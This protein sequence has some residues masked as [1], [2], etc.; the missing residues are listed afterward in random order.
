MLPLPRF[1]VPLEDHEE[2]A[3][4]YQRRG[5]AWGL[6]AVAAGALLAA[7]LY[8]PKRGGG[9]VRLVRVS[10]LDGGDDSGGQPER[11]PSMR[12]RATAGKD[13]LPS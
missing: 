1:L 5:L 6:Y 12:E 7:W 13:P 9:G 8:W 3:A 11:P 4:F 2:A 10:A